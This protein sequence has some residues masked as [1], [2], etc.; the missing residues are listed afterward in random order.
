MASAN[1]A[2]TLHIELL[3][4]LAKLQA[5]MEQIK[6]SV[7]GMESDVARKMKAANDNLGSLGNTA[8]LGKH[9]VQN[10]V[11]QFQDLGVQL[12][13][14]A[15]SSAPLKMTLMALFQ[16]GTQISGVMAQA[17]IGVRGLIAAVLAMAAPFAPVIAVMGALAVGVALVTAEVNKN[18]AVTVSWQNVVL[19][20]FD[21][22]REWVS[23]KLTAAFSA[24][25]TTTGEVWEFVKRATKAAVNFT[26]GVMGLLPRLIADTYKLIG[27][28][29]GDA[30]YSGVNLAADALQAMLDKAAA[31]VNGVTGFFNDAFGTS[32]PKVLAASIPKL[33]N[34]Y[35]GAMSALGS[36]AAKS[37]VGS[38]TKDYVGD[39][40]DAVGGASVKRQLAEN[41]AKAG[42]GTGNSA[43]KAAAKA[44]VDETGKA[45]AE[46]IKQAR[47]TADE[48]AKALAGDLKTGLAQMQDEIVRGT[49]GWL[50]AANDNAKATAAW[51]VELQDTIRLLDGLG[52]FGSTLA[53][54]GAIFESIGSGNW[55]NVNGPLGV[56]GK[57]LGGVLNN[58]FV[59]GMDDDGRWIKSLGEVLRENL[60][61]VFGEAGSFTKTLQAA[62]VGMAA[63]QMVNGSS[64]SGIGSAIGG[65]LGDKLG[66]KVFTKGFEKIAK[67]LGDFAGPLGSILGGILGGALGGLFKTVQSGYAQV[68]GGAVSGTYGRTG[69][70]RSGAETA[71]SGIVSQISALADALGVR[72]GAY[73]FDI[74]KRDDK[75]IVNA[76]DRGLHSFDTE[77]E[78]VAFAIREAVA[79]GAFNGIADGA[80][81]LLEN[82]GDLQ[83]QI[84]KA[85][86][87][88]GVFTSLQEKTDPLGY[89]LGQI[90]KQFAKLTAIFDEAGATAAE[91]AQLEQLI[92]MQRQEVIEDNAA[93]ALTKLNERRSL[94]VRL[95]EAQGNASAALALQREIE[96]SETDATLRSLLDQIYAA[97]DA[98]SAQQELTRATEQAQA[99]FKSF[100]DQLRGFADD[101]TSTGGAASYRGTRAQLMA[102]GSLAAAGNEDALAKLTGVSQAFLDTARNQAS[103]A[104]QYQ[105]DVA[106]VRGY[107]NTAIAVAEGG[108]ASGI[109]DGTP[110][111][112]AAA[113]A[114]VNASL[115]S[116]MQAMRAEV[117]AQRS[118]TRA[119]NEALVI[120]NNKMMRLQERWDRGGSLA[121][122]T[123]EDRPLKTEAA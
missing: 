59:T 23:E 75:Y 69:E 18:S 22:Y 45:W 11:F 105:R 64:N 93:E 13:A 55:Q 110:A 44:L 65:A 88:Q 87:F 90:D 40:A 27:P 16:Q 79:D 83:G 101:L 43:G 2:G 12:A 56:I 9:H 39:I 30:F 67:G 82:S 76:H 32:I 15:G 21:V 24:F 123:D 7:G 94:E 54:I 60:D 8:K 31:A 70:L 62:G 81:R 117:A 100:A 119:A 89:A 52:G 68:R 48:V 10:L 96:R 63:G 38:F 57:S 121:V 95:M 35:A 92:A 78:A 53:N 72:A 28:A 19:G 49:S 113:N 84:A 1:S 74:G 51:N 80:K 107:L 36:A 91:Y 17:G 42:K 73:D 47:D 109:A 46:I 108:L 25:G 14:A 3:T 4:N 61:K 102:T 86:T 58:S 106:F 122:V 20:A 29:I 50:E 114:E 99:R 116:E 118:E 77:A 98:A 5:E 85:I 26:I 97:E 37:L 111:Q 71:A 104:A 34:P 33:T 120:A 112:I 66:T 41:A 6:R 115:L 103:T